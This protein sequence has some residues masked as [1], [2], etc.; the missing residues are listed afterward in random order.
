[1]ILIL[2]STSDLKNKF[3]KF[4]PFGN[5]VL[6]I[7]D[8]TESCSVVTHFDKVHGILGRHILIFFT[9]S[10]IL[11]QLNSKFIPPPR[12]TLELRNY[13]HA[14]TSWIFM[15]LKS[16]PKHKLCKWPSNVLCTIRAQVRSADHFSYR[17]LYLK[18]LHVISD[19]CL[20]HTRQL[21]N[22]IKARTS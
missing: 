4:I 15:D 10:H 13:S 22:Y 19:C 20:T 16:T 9:C 18:L 21:S 1:M 5:N 11:H 12:L 7:Y 8:P 6:P 3:I 2:N 17:C 14:W